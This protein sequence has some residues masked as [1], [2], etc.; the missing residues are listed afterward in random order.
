MVAEYFE[1]YSAGTAKSVDSSSR[2]KS[3]ATKPDRT[4]QLVM[5]SGEAWSTDGL[6]E[7]VLLIST[8]ANA[9]R[10]KHIHLSM[11]SASFAERLDH[12]P[13][14]LLSPSDTKTESPKTKFCAYL[15]AHCDRS[16]RELMYDALNALRPVDA[17][18]KCAGSSRPPDQTKMAS[19]LAIFYNDDAVRRYAPYKFVL[20]F[21]NTRAAGYVT[22]KLVNA[23]LAGSVPVYWGDS[24]TVSELFNPESFIDCG[25]FDSLQDC[26]EYVVRV[27]DSPEMYTRMRREAPVANMT[28]FNE[29]FSWHP[30][31][32]SRFM[33][34]AVLRH[35][36][37]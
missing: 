14:S 18:G 22:E 25:R 13:L 34:D 31:V 28:A 4:T 32:P 24:K 7:R 6:D 9:N 5:L 16:D 20:A 3:G 8:L 23:F 36:H 21:E 17:L 11:A 33:A 35:F 19:R 12:G 2:N 29:A 1:R 30:T 26:A 27:D 15:Y 10:T 37:N